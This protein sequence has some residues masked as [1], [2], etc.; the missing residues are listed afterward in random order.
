MAYT[1]FGDTFDTTQTQTGGSFRRWIAGAFAW[2]SVPVQ[3]EATPV[4]EPLRRKLAGPDP[5]D[6]R[7]WGYM[8][9]LD[10]EVGF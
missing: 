4:T 3:E 6:H 7:A 5:R 8:A 2:R 1:G 9:D 10:M